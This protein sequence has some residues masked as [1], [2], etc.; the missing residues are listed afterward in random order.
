MK[1][2]NVRTKYMIPMRLWSVVVTHDVQPVE[3]EST[4]AATTCGTG[5]TL[6]RGASVVAAMRQSG[7]ELRVLDVSGFKLLALLRAL[8][9]GGLDV[10][11]AV[12]EPALVLVDGHGAHAG[13]HVR[14][15]APAQLGAL[16]EED[17]PARLGPELAGDLEPGVVGVA[18][19]GVELAAEL[20]DPPGVR[21]VLGVDVERHRRVDGDD[22]LLVGEGRAEVGAGLAVV[23]VGEAPEVLLAVDA[24]VQRLAV[25]R[26]ATARVGELEAVGRGLR[27]VA[28]VV[29]LDERDDREDDQDQRGADRPADLQA[30]VAADL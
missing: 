12:A 8:L 11:L 16:A 15:V 26:Q 21:D 28:D 27:R 5:A 24:D 18:G 2:P 1:N 25:G 9:L 23:A 22:Q 10:G 4:M 3:D 30:R 13:G 17:G 19:D 6:G 7:P 29:E 20:R 14:V